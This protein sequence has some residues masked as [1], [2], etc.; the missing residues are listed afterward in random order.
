[1][2]ILLALASAVGWG[3]GD[4]VAGLAS[5]R[6][7]SLSIVVSSQAVGAV[8]L[9]VLARLAGGEADA[10]SLAWGAAGGVG[11]GIGLAL[12]YHA[13]ALGPM[14]V[15]APL[16]AVVAAIAPVAFGL[17]TGDGPSGLA[18]VG[19]ALALAAVVLVSMSS[20]A[21]AP[22]EALAGE[23]GPPPGGGAAA[24]VTRTRVQP[25]ALVAALLAGVGF[26]V[27]FICFD[28]AGA[29]SGLWPVVGARVATVVVLGAL[30]VVV[31]QS[32]VV[33]APARP[34][35][36][37]VGVLDSAAQ[38]LYL[39]ASRA[40]LLPVVS[41]IASLYPAVTVVLAGAVLREPVARRQLF[42]LLVAAGGVTLIVLG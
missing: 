2:G 12:L 9:V 17:A 38:A 25:R 1:V 37:L 16:A 24:A 29:D 7:S 34:A 21:E 26:G 42:A 11:S 15:V 39:L 31:G 5:R 6:T 41:V 33:P 27:F 13:L 30:A 40:A 3:A 20:E 10:A 8:L 4:F 23:G 36:A 22:P 19:I 14:T 28:F 35:T 32:P 18:L